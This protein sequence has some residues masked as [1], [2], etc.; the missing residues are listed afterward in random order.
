MKIGNVMVK[1]TVV[2]HQMKM[3]VQV[4]VRKGTPVK[5]TGIPVIYPVKCTLDPRDGQKPE[6]FE[7]PGFGFDPGFKMKNPGFSG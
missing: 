3:I 5:C 7:N 4:Q 1:M 6:F 2:T